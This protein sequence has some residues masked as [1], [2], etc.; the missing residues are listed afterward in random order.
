ML[1]QLLLWLTCSRGLRDPGVQAVVSVS[2]L[3]HSD[4]A[5]DG[6]RKRLL[7]RRVDLCNR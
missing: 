2:S 1:P 4:S 7:K 5:C 3:P 6:M